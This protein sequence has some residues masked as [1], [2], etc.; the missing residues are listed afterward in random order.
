MNTAD[1]WIILLFIF[2]LT[3]GIVLLITASQC[4]ASESEDPKKCS[5]TKTGLGI[6]FIV[7]ACLI[8]LY[9]IVLLIKPDIFSTLKT[10]GK[11]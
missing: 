3:L 8:G 1:T 9:G 11:Y 6:T 5:D 2:F 10:T 4:K 7:F